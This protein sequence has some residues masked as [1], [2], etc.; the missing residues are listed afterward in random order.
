MAS[1]NL[2][3]RADRARYRQDHADELNAIEEGRWPRD[4]AD[5]VRWVTRDPKVVARACRDCIAYVDDLE[6]RIAAGEGGLEGF[7]AG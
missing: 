7:E 6:A 3:C 5:V 2:M 1:Y 4:T